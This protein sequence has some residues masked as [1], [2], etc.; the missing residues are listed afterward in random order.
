ML[1]GAS[2]LLLMGIAMPLKH[3]AGMPGAVSVAGWLHG[4]LFIA[5][6]MVTCHAWAVRK[7]SLKMAVLA[8]VAAVVPFGPFWLDRKLAACE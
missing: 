6:G 1:E 4:G 2:F 8:L 3:F 7:L 5:Y